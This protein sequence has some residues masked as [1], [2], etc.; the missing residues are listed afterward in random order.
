MAV[1]PGWAR[2][3]I[4]GNGIGAGAP[5]LKARLI[6]SV[7]GLVAQSARD[8]ALPLLFAALAPQAKGGAYYG[9]SGWG[10]TSG[11]PGLARIFPQAADP[12]AGTRLWE[13]SE[14]LT[15]ATLGQ[16]TKL[17]GSDSEATPSDRSPAPPV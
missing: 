3:D 8:G 6:E 15:G 17:P 5:G 2:T 13:I 1:H 4:I 16:G 14:N 9:P 11:E 7:F 12:V 10:E